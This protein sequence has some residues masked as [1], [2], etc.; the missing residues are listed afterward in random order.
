LKFILTIL[1]FSFCLFVNAQNLFDTSK[2]TR[3]STIIAASH[4]KIFIDSLKQKTLKDTLKFS[5]NDLLF[6]T[7]TTNNK[8]YSPLFIITEKYS[9]KLDIVDGE[10]V[11]EFTNQYFDQNIIE[12]III[13]DTTVGKAIY[14]TY[15]SNGCVLVYL[16]KG[17][18]FN[19]L[20]AG[21]KMR[22][23]KYGGDN[24]DQFQTG[25]VMIRE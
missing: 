22:N 8:S 6:S 25:D 14:G 5:R 15:A 23:K 13:V 18:K 19:P 4:L 21:L 24:F 20:V 7:M 9:Y 3:L 11:L 10:K 12:K 16:K 17:I 2:S 1:S